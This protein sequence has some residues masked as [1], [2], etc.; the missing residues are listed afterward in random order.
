[1]ALLAL[2]DIADDDG[3]VVYAKGAKRSQESLAKK[4]RMSVATFRRVTQ[5]LAEQ[6]FLEITRESPR[7]ENEYRVMVTAQSERS[8]V[9]GQTVE[10]ERSERSLLSG[11]PSYRRSDVDDVARKRASRIPDPFVVT[12]EMRAWAAL[13]VPG[14]DVDGHTREFVDY[15][16]AKSGKDASKADW[17]ATWR[18]WMRRAH[19]WGKPAESPATEAY[20]PGDEWMVFNR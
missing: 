19:R 5:D 12:A 15:W 10:N 17:V 3:H 13:E 7:S 8:Q 9:S 18:N 14:L 11:H 16:R 20:A 4:A 6:G 1:M 2:A